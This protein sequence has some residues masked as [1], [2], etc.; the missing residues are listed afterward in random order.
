MN[1]GADD[2]VP[3]LH[4]ALYQLFKSIAALARFLPAGFVN[5]LF[6]LTRYLFFLILGFAAWVRSFSD[7]SIGLWLV[8]GF[9]FC[10]LLHSYYGRFC[11]Y[12]DDRLE[13]RY[14]MLRLMPF[15]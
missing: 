2:Y 5:P 6:F 11:P 7:T 9:V 3:S 14:G 10:S 12:P 4:F 15:M 13:T 8:I 1:K